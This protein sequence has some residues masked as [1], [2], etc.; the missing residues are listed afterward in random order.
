MSVPTIAL[1]AAISPRATYVRHVLTAGHRP[2]VLSGAEIRGR[3]RQWAAGYYRARS[4]AVA[5]A[6]AAGVSSA[7][8]LDPERH[9]WVRVWTRDGAPVQLTL[10]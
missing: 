2:G 6:A 9:R 8:V 4:Q 1:S 7:V 10:D 5:L 3:A